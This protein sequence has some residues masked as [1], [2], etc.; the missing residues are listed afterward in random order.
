VTFSASSY[1]DFRGAD[2]ADPT[3]CL[4]TN[5]SGQQQRRLRNFFLLPLEDEPSV[6]NGLAALWP[7]SPGRTANFTFIGRT[8]DQSTFRYA[9]RWSV[10]RQETVTIGGTQRSVFVLTRTQEGMFNNNYLGTETYWLDAETQTWLKRT[11]A[12]TRGRAAGS[13]WEAQSIVVPR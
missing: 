7:L 9:E 6:R 5:A 13:N 1:L 10:E 11:V 12:V 2:S 8:Q 4:A 3:I